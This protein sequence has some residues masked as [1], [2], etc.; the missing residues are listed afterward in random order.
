[1]L[2]D[3]ETKYSVYMKLV[4]YDFEREKRYLFRNFEIILTVCLPDCCLVHSWFL[5]REL[6]G[7]GRFS[8]TRFVPGSLRVGVCL[9]KV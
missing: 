9:V 7:Q 2:K 6:R 5:K 4:T 1:M 3:Y 8:H